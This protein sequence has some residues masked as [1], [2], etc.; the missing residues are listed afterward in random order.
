MPW[1]RRN[2]S[3]FLARFHPQ[4]SFTSRARLH[5]TFAVRWMLDAERAVSGD[6]R[7]R[8]KALSRAPH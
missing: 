2:L 6:A 5:T 8:K 4:R 3:V 1:T 7:A